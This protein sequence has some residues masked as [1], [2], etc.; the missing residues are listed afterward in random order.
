[1][2][3]FAV[4]HANIVRLRDNRDRAGLLQLADNVTLSGHPDATAVAADALEAVEWIDRTSPDTVSADR[5][6]SIRVGD[7]LTYMHAGHLVQGIA[8][9]IDGGRVTTNLGHTV[10]ITG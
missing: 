7:I 8:L 2:D 1:V 3:Y 4:N 5:A 9:S 6:H 10:T